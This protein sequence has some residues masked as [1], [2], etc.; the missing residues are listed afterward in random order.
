MITSE[1]CIEYDKKSNIFRADEHQFPELVSIKVVIN[2][3]EYSNYKIAN[4]KQYI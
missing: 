2:N 4:K 1:K 3:V